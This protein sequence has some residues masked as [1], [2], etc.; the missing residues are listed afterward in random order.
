MTSRVGLRSRAL[1]E[2]RYVD[3]T[4]PKDV[5]GASAETGPDDGYV[6]RVRWLR[7]EAS[8]VRHSAGEHLEQAAEALAAG[9][10]GSA[11]RL[12]T[13][14]EMASCHYMAYDE[15]ATAAGH[16]GLAG[17]FVR[18]TP[19][20]EIELH[21]ADAAIRRAEGHRERGEALRHGEDAFAVRR[22]RQLAEEAEEKARVAELRAVEILE[23]RAGI[24]WELQ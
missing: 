24:A 11:S 15:L 6:Q 22:H 10:P 13:L 16:R 1:T 23:H 8:R 12:R 5:D 3:G 4:R 17:R 2:L 14:A 19:A 7:G 9:D 20:R 21:R 18:G